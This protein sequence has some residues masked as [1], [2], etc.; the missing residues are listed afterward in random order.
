MG[1]KSENQRLGTDLSLPWWVTTEVGV[2]HRM[3]QRRLSPP[4]E[5]TAP[6][7]SD[8]P[9]L[10]MDLIFFKKQS[11][12]DSTGEGGWAVGLVLCQ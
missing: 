2:L 5:Y 8:R 6:R 12:P 11:P 3:T 9:V 1:G 4:T 10:T 7:G